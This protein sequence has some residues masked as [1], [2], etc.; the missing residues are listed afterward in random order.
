[1][2]SPEQEAPFAYVE[3]PVHTVHLTRPFHLKK[4]EVTWHEWNAVRDWALQNG[5]PDLSPGQN[6]QGGDDSGQHPV[7]AVSWY[8]A[9]KWTNAR[10]EYEN[11]VTGSTLTP[12]YTVDGTV[13]RENEK[14]PDCDFAAGG[15]RLPTEA[16]WEYA[17]RAGSITAY[18]FGD[19]AADLVGTA[20]FAGNASRQTHPVGHKQPNAWN[21][22]DM[23]GNVSEWCWDIYTYY[24][25]GEQSDPT[26]PGSGFQRVVRGGSFWD[27]SLDCR[28][29]SRSVQYPQDNYLTH[30]GF[31]WARR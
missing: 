6:G 10:T 29:A 12:C 28:S 18:S 20:W 9:L 14:V 21:L 19:S 2:G 27:Q 5:Y 24:E 30:I 15:Y 26:G 3:R 7:T 4:T 11:A 31:R 17:C 16:E 22:Y 23:H 13:Y 8:D 1:M 25:A